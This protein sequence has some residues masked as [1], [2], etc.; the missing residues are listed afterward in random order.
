MTE[1]GS[2]CLEL[3]VASAI[4]AAIQVALVFRT[5]EMLIEADKFGESGMANVAF[6]SIA[7]PGAAVSL[8][9]NVIGFCM[10]SDLLLGNE[11]VFILLLDKVVDILSVDLWGT[12]AGCSFQMMRDTAVSRKA[13]L[14]EWAFRTRA[15]MSLRVHML[16]SSQIIII[17]SYNNHTILRLFSF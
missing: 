9:G 10:P 7:V 6:V 2:Q 12:R 13:T 5:V 14:T 15:L 16:S 11:V 17:V 8:I 1:Q 3:H 4:R